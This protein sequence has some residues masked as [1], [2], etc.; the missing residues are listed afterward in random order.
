VLLIVLAVTDAGASKHLVENSSVG[1]TE[2]IANLW[3]LTSHAAY[4]AS[5][6][7]SNVLA[8]TWSTIGVEAA[9]YSQTRTTLVATAQTLV[10]W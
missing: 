4:A 10:M 7:S 8:F 3:S 1:Y 2:A 6:I 9:I 5:R